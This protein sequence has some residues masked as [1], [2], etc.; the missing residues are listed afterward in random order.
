[1]SILA[2]LTQKLQIKPQVRK[3]E[4]IKVVILPEQQAP[5][6]AITGAKEDGAP[7]KLVAKDMVVNLDPVTK[8]INEKD[9]GSTAVDLLKRLEAHKLTKVVKKMPEEAVKES[10]APIVEETKKPGPRKQKQRTVL[11]EDIERVEDVVEGG[12][13]MKDRMKE[14]GLEAAAADEGAA[15][16]QELINA[17]SKPVKRYSKKVITGVINLGPVSMMQIGDTPINKRLPPE[18]VYDIKASSYYMNNREV[19]VKFIND[20]FE[21]YREDLQDETKDISCD[22]IGKDTGKLGLLTHQKIVRDYINLYTPYRG[23]LLFHGLGSGKTC[24]SIAI[25]EGLKSYRQVIIMTPASLK[26]NY[27]EEI[28]KCGDLLFRKNQFWEWISVDNNMELIEPLAQVLGGIR[29][30]YENKKHQEW[31]D[32][33]RRHRGVWLVNVTKPTNY[34]ELSTSDKKVLNDQLDVM[35]QLKY[36]FINYNGLRR[37][38]FKQMTNDFTVNIFDGAVVII[39]EAHNLVSRIVNKISSFHKFSERKR[40]PGE[41]LP[42]P[43]ALQLYEFLLR[44]E[45]CRVVMLTGTPMI[46]YPNEIGVLYNILRGYIKTW[47]I[48]INKEQLK[49]STINKSTFQ[50][51]F[52]K[53]KILDYVNYE[54]NILTITRNPFGFEN[55]IKEDEGYKGVYNRNEKVGDDGKIVLDDKGVMTDEEFVGRIIKI[56]KKNDITVSPRSIQFTVNTALPDTLEPFIS[57]FIDRDNGKLINDFKFKR[58]IIGLTSYFKSAQE[59]LLPAY[60]RDINRHIIRIPMSD[61][62]FQIYAV[63]RHDERDSEGK[64]KGS[65]K[66]DIDGLFV[67]PKSTY[68]IFSRL[69]CNFVMPTPPGRPTPRLFKAAKAQDWLNDYLKESNDKRINA[70]QENIKNYIASL[71]PEFESNKEMTDLVKLQVEQYVDRFIRQQYDVVDFETFLSKKYQDR[72]VE[73]AQEK[74]A[75]RLEE[76][77]QPTKA[78][79]KE[80]KV[81]TKVQAHEKG[82]K[83]LTKAQ[84]KEAKDR[85]KAEEKEA[86]DLAKAQEKE[87]KDLAKAQEKEAKDRQK[88]EEKEAKDRQKAEEKEAKALAKAQKKGKGLSDSESDTDTSSDSSSDSEDDEYVNELAGL[89]SDSKIPSYLLGGAKKKKDGKDEEEEEEDDNDDDD[90]AKASNVIQENVPSAKKDAGQTPNVDELLEREIYNEDMDDDAEVRSGVIE[91]YKDQDA[92]ERTVEELEGDE[93]LERTATNPDYKRAIKEALDFLQ[94]H[95]SDYLSLEALRKYSPK[96]LTMIENIDDIDHP[97]LHLVYSQFRSMEG[98]GIFALALEANGYARFK[99][100]R[101]GVGWDLVTRDEDMGKPHYALYT[102]T[103]DAEEREIIRNIYNGDWNYIPNNIAAIL[104]ERS[105]NNNMGEIIKVF[106]I[107]SAGSEG[108]NLRN[109]RYVHIMEPYWH[110]VRVEQVIGRARRICSHQGLEQK[111]RT[112]EVF[113]YLMSFTQEQLDSEF[114]IEIKMKD[115]SNLEPFLPQSSD[116]KLFE[117]STIKEQLSDQLLRAIKSSS[118]DCITHSKSNRKEGIACLS[119]GNVSNNK[120]SYNPN[121]EQDQNDNVADMNTKINDW[122]VREIVIQSTGKKYMLRLDTKQLYDYESVLQAKQFPGLNPILL[123]RLEQNKNGEYEIIKYKA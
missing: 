52:A 15:E 3:E 36:R 90:D 57:N 71:P 32:F 51:M 70:V 81:L 49:S 110:P 29:I 33:I 42:I 113:I 82:T 12:P 46:N 35:I 16:P 87:A 106:M 99:I 66:I 48:A 94:R 74:A 6:N 65:A 62:Q 26:R 68:K 120:F 107:T 41:T 123:G 108:I 92:N 93:I 8:I 34:D 56:L 78:E 102:G 2:K 31:I 61:Y 116:E 59:E 75:R 100:V 53:E 43:L 72:I 7:D 101:N 104:R 9:N 118:I 119:F 105:T 80:A 28:K 103:E 21:P 63:A 67:K 30:N 85:Q 83:A 47:N 64:K 117:I 22:T 24:S 60:N 39:D 77:Q 111:F 38:K 45:N 55:K 69:F 19:F 114:G 58:R 5:G 13:Q 4:D 27:M 20:I 86:K 91:G 115:R 17:P 11:L 40:G 14:V 96:F 1:M 95:S 84:E 89:D 37:S 97:G 109:T 54:T 44:A 25:A 112:V 98:I 121:I 79:A 122:D 76:V 18:P 23:L 73:L 50:E 10:M 88:A